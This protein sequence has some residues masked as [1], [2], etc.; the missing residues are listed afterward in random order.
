MVS[1]E[2]MNW[3]VEPGSYESRDLLQTRED[4]D[5]GILRRRQHLVDQRLRPVAGDN[6]I[7]ERSADINADLELMP[8]TLCHRSEFPRP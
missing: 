4:G 5:R 6:E 2:R 8:P 1:T 3:R 7:R